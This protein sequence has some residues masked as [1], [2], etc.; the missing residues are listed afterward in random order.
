MLKAMNTKSTRYGKCESCGGKIVE[1]HATVDC[2]FH[3]QLFEFENVPVGVCQECG[4]RIY[5]GPVLEQLER[6][7]ASAAKIKKTIQVP[8]AEFEPA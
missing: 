7:A 3:G 8:V 5:K 4:Q 6:L 1:K 2:R